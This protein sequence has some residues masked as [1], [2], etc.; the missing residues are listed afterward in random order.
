MSFTLSTDDC[1][2]D[3]INPILDRALSGPGNKDGWILEP[4]MRLGYGL[5]RRL[6]L[7]LEYYTDLGP[8]KNLLP[9]DK[10]AHLLGFF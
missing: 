4:C 3:T 1:R 5:N 6:D 8:I 9:P 7:S 10:Q 2:R